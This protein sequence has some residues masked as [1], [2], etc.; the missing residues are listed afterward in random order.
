MLIAVKHFGNFNGSI[1]VF[2]LYIHIICLLIKN[3]KN[4]GLCAPC[5]VSYE[6]C[7]I[8]DKPDKPCYFLLLIMG[9]VEI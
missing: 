4:S 6:T 2:L 9:R 7:Y 5:T 3:F 1:L 8:F